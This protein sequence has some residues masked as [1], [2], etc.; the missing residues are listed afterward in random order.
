M[1]MPDLLIRDIDPDMKRLIEERAQ[2]HARNLSDEVKSLIQTGLSVPEPEMKM[3]DWLFSLVP[4]EYRVD[5][6]FEYRGPESKPP[7]FE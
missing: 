6:D 5:L 1:P 2:R 3:G 7:D 4:P